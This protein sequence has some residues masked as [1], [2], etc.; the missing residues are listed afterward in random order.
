MIVELDVN[1]YSK[2]TPLLSGED[3]TNV[4]LMSIVA[5]NNKGKIFVDNP[6]HP[7]TAIIWAIASI[8]FF[9]GDCRN[10][11]FT[12]HLNSYMGRKIKTGFLGYHRGHL[13]HHRGYE[14]SLGQGVK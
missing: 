12:A 6:E 11:E 3:K 8:A 1:E 9:V 5:G 4:A 10:S 13:V 2:I 14:R 7:R